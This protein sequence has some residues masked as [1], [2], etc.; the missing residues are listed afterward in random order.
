MSPHQLAE[1]LVWHGIH[2]NGTVEATD[3]RDGNV[4]IA[5]LVYVQVPTFDGAPRV[6]VDGYDTDV[7]C[8]PPR[9]NV[10]DLASDIRDAVNKLTPAAIASCSIH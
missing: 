8:Y 5:D 3:Q 6:V 4:T 7:R 1:A 10:A 9:A 2:V